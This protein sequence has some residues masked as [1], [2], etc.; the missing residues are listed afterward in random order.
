MLLYPLE[1]S[2]VKEAK[3]PAPKL[4]FSVLSDAEVLYAE[5]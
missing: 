3:C 2:R 4:A 5:G 1:I